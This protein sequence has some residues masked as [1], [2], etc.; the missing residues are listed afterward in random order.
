MKDRFLNANQSVE[1]NALLLLDRLIIF[2]HHACYT[3]HYRPRRALLGALESM[4]SIFS[5]FFF[6]FFFFFSSSSFFNRRWI[7]LVIT[8]SLLAAQTTA[9][10]LSFIEPSVAAESFTI[11]D[12]V[13]V[14]WT[15]DFDYTTLLVW[16]GPLRDGSYG[17][18]VLAG[19][20]LTWL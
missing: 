7:V 6:F 1:G 15:T 12:I 19:K 2:F 20:D 13:S 3:G 9:N 16:H 4:A 5:F 8:L 17:Q 11:G 14:R 10:S 18:D